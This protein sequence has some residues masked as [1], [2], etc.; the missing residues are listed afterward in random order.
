MLELTQAPFSTLVLQITQTSENH[1]PVVR[2]FSVLWYV[3]TYHCHRHHT[4]CAKAR[5][6]RGG[7]GAPTRAKRDGC[8]W[9]SADGK[10]DVPPILA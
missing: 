6:K 10:P 3:G 9:R 1:L 7:R 4:G 2:F 8:A 5:A